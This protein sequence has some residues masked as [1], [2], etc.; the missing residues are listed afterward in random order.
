MNGGEAPVNV[1]EIYEQATEW[2]LKKPELESRDESQ[3]S[4]QKGNQVGS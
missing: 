3:E 1:G 4:R 2:Y